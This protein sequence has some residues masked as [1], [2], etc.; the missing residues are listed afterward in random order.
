MDV[1]LSSA[2]EG[3]PG[4][5]CNGA[6]RASLAVIFGVDGVVKLRRRDRLRTTWQ[7]MGVAPAAMRLSPAGLRL[8]IDA[9]P[10]SIFL[11][12][13][14]VRGLRLHRRP[15]A[16]LLVVDLF[17]GVG[18]GTRGVSGLDH[19]DVRRVL[20]RRV[21]GVQGLRTAV[22]LLDQPVAAI[23]HVAAQLTGGRVRVHG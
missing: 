4:S 5:A 7:T 20:D 13:E 12:W 17:P 2:P 16:H 18:R 6:V 10:D 21:G 22:H 15:G 8:S 9:A 14:T 11:P 23:D 3:P 1:R 19:A